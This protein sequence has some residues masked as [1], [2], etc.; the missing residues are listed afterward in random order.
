MCR[1][2]L[3]VGCFKGHRFESLNI[4]YCA[5]EKPEPCS[6]FGESQVSRHLPR[7]LFYTI[8]HKLL[9]NEISSPRAQLFSLQWASILLAAVQR[10][11]LDK[12][13]CCL[14]HDAL[15]YGKT[16]R[17]CDSW[18]LYYWGEGRFQFLTRMNF[19]WDNES[20]CSTSGIRLWYLST[21]LFH[22][23]E[24]ERAQRDIK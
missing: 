18:L 1:N 22:R 9:K 20:F 14:R 2:K 11:S 23:F 24:H 13:N 3:P 6:R 8:H 17:R 5:K 7:F 4:L 12:S 16:R 21:E 10:W 15:D 19:S